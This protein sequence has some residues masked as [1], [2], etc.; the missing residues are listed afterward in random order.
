[1]YRLDVELVGADKDA[2]LIKEGS[3][4]FTE[5]YYTDLFGAEGGIAHSYTR[6]VY[7]DVYPGIDWV[8]Y[9]RDNKLKHEFV[10]HKDG[11]PSLIKLR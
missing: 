1:M 7:K 5:R 8:L 10:V 11:D 9:V 6:A 4:Y 3:Q 2:L